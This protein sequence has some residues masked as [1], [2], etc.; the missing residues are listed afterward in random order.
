MGQVGP[1]ILYKFLAGKK[2]YV[3]LHICPQIV[4]IQKLS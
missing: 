3:L 1:E 2:A 4:F